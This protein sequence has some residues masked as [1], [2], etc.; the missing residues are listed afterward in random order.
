MIGI[1]DLAGG[2]QPM[3]SNDDRAI[4]SSITARETPAGPMPCLAACARA[5]T[6]AKALP[7]FISKVLNNGARSLSR[8]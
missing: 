2:A 4:T 6:Y 3:S 1:I 5:K 7:S 8:Q